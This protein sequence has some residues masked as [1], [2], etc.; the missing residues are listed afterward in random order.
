MGMKT[1]LPPA[2]P[3]VNSKYAQF[4]DHVSL[5]TLRDGWRVA[6]IAREIIA[7]HPDLGWVPT[8]HAIRRIAKSIRR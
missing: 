4:W 7:D 8:Y 1:T 2:P 6:D 5:R 3:P